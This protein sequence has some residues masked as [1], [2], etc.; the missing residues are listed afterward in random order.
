MVLILIMMTSVYAI[1]ADIRS[2]GGVKN[3]K[4]IMVRDGMCGFFVDA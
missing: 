1:A 2:N 4:R 3:L